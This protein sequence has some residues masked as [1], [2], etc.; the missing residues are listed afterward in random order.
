[1]FHRYNYY[2]TSNCD[3]SWKNQSLVNEKK[4]WAM[5]LL[6]YVYLLLIV[7]LKSMDEEKT[8]K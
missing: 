2:G 4:F 3:I 6:H 7:L 1:M 8:T 5:I